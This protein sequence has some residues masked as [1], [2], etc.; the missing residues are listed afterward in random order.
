M[1][2]S[3]FYDLPMLVGEQYMLT[4]IIRETRDTILYRATQRELRRDV[5][6]ESL[7][8]SAMDNQRK[9][10][11][12]LDS[13]K[14]QASA[15]GGD[16]TCVLEVFETEG[17]WLIIKENPAGVPLDIMLSD[18]KKLPALDICQLL[19]TL[20]QVCLRFDKE[21]TASARFHLEDIFCHQHS[22]K[23]NNLALAGTRPLS[24]SR[25]YL[26]DAAREL[27]PLLDLQTRLAGTLASFMRRITFN[28]DDSAVKIALFLAEFARLHTLMLQPPKEEATPEE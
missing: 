25:L 21:N 24:T 27:V 4:T 28:A 7:R 6:V 22:F 20:C 14:A 16:L 5:I 19:I 8:H 1:P 13:A 2:K 9:V 17:T 10:Q 12:F 15:Q 26:A 11:M 3:D 18:G 23:I